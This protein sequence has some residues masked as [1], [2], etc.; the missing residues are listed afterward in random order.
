M[1][2]T[3]RVINKVTLFKNDLSLVFVIHL[4]PAFQHKHDL[5]IVV[6]VVPAAGLTHL[7]GP[8]GS[9]IILSVSR[10]IQAEIADRKPV[11]QSGHGL[12]TALACPAQQK[13]PVRR[14]QVLFC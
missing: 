9:G 4:Y 5:K 13:L 3:P 8:G 2:L 6:M 12:I 14:G 11:A 10:S 7:I 1:N